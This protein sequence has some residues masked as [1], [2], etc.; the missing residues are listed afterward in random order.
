VD[1][2]SV[3]KSFLIT[4]LV[5][6]GLSKEMS[7]KAKASSV[8]L[9]IG[10]DL[11]FG[12]L[13]WAFDLGEENRFGEARILLI[14]PENKFTAREMLG[15]FPKKYWT[16][17]SDINCLRNTMLRYELTRS[18]PMNTWKLFFEH[19]VVISRGPA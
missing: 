4:P 3:I 1:R 6:A 19:G 5:L 8:E 9:P 18:L 7:A 13:Q 12:A 14:G 11:S 16:G 2:R 15:G 17:D 10:C